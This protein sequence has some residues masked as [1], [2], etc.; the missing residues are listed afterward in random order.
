MPQLTKS[1]RAAIAKFVM[2]GKEHPVLIRPDGDVLMLH[3]MHYGDEI[4]S[5]EEIDHGAKTSVGGAELKLAERL[6]N[7]LSKDK[8][9]PNEFEDTYRQKILKAAERNVVPRELI[10]A[11]SSPCIS[12]TNRKTSRPRR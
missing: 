7:D 8:F 3:T 5:S 11:R 12:P 2:R 1:E 4:R 6:I 10:S 9:E